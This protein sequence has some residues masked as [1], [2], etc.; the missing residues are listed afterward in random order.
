M[1]RIWRLAGWG[2]F[3][4]GDCKSGKAVRVASPEQLVA[5]SASGTAVFL[6]RHPKVCLY[7]NFR[8]SH[9]CLAGY[10][11]FTTLSLLSSKRISL[12]SSFLS[13]RSRRGSMTTL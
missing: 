9:F 5:G 4:D 11:F 8:M 2:L 7:A 12:S 6:M 13:M 10:Y 3:F 1:A